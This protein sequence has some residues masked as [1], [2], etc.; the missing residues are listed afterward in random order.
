[1]ENPALRIPV[2]G[3]I[4]DPGEE[5]LVGER[6]DTDVVGSVVKPTNVWHLLRI[7]RRNSLCRW[8]LSVGS[9][10][11]ASVSNS[12]FVQRFRNLTKSN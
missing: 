2:L 8:L 11:R 5:A 4:P 7:A 12:S 10:F 1:M 6:E 3:D 9:N